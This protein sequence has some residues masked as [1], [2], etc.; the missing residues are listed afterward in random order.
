MAGKKLNTKS[1]KTAEE[2]TPT[3]EVVQ[4][5]VEQTTQVSVVEQTT[6]LSENKQLSKPGKTIIVKSKDGSPLD[7]SKFDGLT[8]LVSKTEINQ[9]NSLFLVF[10]TIE[11]SES[12]LASFTQN[13]NVKYSYYKVFVALSSNLDNSNVETSKQELT[14]FIQSNTDST[15]L[16]CKFYRKGPSYMNCGYLLLDTIDGMKKLISKESELKQFKTEH[17]SGT[18]YRFNNN[19]YTTQTSNV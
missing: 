7:L 2:T 6:E 8:G 12:A 16:F 17:F 19:K 13:Y 10:D 1:K 5:V 9:H 18:F 11:H 15:V 4:P 3:V 14:D